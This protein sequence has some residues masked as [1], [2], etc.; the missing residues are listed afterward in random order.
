MDGEHWTDI[1]EMWW[2]ALGSGQIGDGQMTSYDINSLC[3]P[4]HPKLNNCLQNRLLVT[5]ELLAHL[6]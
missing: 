5:T 2:W 6:R 3:D 1:L 4:D